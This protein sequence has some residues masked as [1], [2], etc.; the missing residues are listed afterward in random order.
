[1][2]DIEWAKKKAVRREVKDHV[3]RFLLYPLFWE[4]QSRNLPQGLNWQ[5]I[6]FDE[7]NQTQI[8]NKH[9]VYCFVV[10]PPNTIGL[11]Q[12]QYLMYIGKASST[13][14]RARYGHYINEKNGKGIGKQPPRIKV[15]EILND[16]FGYIY[17]YFIEELD[18]KK[19]IE[20]EDKLL[21][22]FMPYVNSLIPRA[23]IK[24]EFKH[25]Y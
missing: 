16:F 4:D 24:E 1:M 11:F 13:G 15:Q 18:K 3:R 9:G 25:I 17:F 20:Y 14:L 12:T 19:V 23:S 10:E 21:D 5:K 6:K 7:N 8:P 2:H 22:T